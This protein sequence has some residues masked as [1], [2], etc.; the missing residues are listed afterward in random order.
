[1]RLWED[2]E[3]EGWLPLWGYGRTERLRLVAPVRLWE[4]REIEGWLP[5]WGYERTERLRLV[6]PCV[7]TGK[8][9]KLI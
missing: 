4:D 2:R 3:I 1:M 9:K 6:E 5:L 7:A 8:S